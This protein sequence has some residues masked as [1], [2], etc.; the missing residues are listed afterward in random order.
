VADLDAA[1]VV[2]VDAAS[3][4]CKGKRLGARLDQVR[5]PLVVEGQVLRELAVPV[6]KVI[7]ARR[8]LRKPASDPRFSDRPCGY[9]A[10]PS[11][12]RG[13]I[14]PATGGANGWREVPSI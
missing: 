8:H 7:S 11:V 4:A 14:G 10:S 13:P 3:L 9:C 5:D 1:V 2:L 6:N 12:P